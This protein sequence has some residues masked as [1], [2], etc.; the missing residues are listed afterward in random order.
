VKAFKILDRTGDGFVTL[1]DIRGTY[2]AAMHPDVKSGKRTAEEI[3]TEFL[4]TFEQHYNTI[5]GC[6]TLGTLN[7][8]TTLLRCRTQA[9]NK[10][11]QQLAPE[12][13]T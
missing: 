9:Q 6:Q 8:R 7:Q 10:K 1:D 2:N 3:L 11:C 4:E 12:K 13:L 5:N